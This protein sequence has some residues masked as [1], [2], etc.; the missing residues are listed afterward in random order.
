MH[1]VRLSIFSLRSDV[2]RHGGLGAALAGVCPD[3]RYPEPA[4]RPPRPRRIT[5]Q[6]A[7]QTEAELLRI[8]QQAI[9]NA[10]RHAGAQNLWVTLRSRL[11][12]RD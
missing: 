1:E 7:A 12:A 11:R 10:R 2:D 6:A 4:H 5:H 8:A 9:G 3:D